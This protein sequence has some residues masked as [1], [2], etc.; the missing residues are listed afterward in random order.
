M[1]RQIGAKLVRS[2]GLVALTG[3]F[4]TGPAW[5]DDTLVIHGTKITAFV[6]VDT[7]GWSPT[8]CGGSG[9]VGA[10]ASGNDS[11]VSIVVHVPSVG[12]AETAFSLGSITNP[13]GVTPAFV[14]T[15]TCPACFAEPQPG[16]YRLAARPS[17]GNWATGTYTVLLTVATP[18]P[19]K[20]VV[21]PID[22]P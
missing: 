11:V 5:S 21:V 9:S 3:M 12:L 13:G 19:D 15:A 18:G 10:A 22:I 20:K 4:S 8:W 16:V 6:D 7:C 14:T 17:F 2:L 1:K